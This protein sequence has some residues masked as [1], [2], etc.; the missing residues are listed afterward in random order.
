[1]ASATLRTSSTNR[2]YSGLAWP[3]GWLHHEVM[4]RQEQDRQDARDTLTRVYLDQAGIRAALAR[5]R[6]DTGAT[7]SGAA[8]PGL[9]SRDATR[10]EI[11]EWRRATLEAADSAHHAILERLTASFDSAQQPR[12][13]PRERQRILITLDRINQANEGTWYAITSEI[14]RMADSA[15]AANAAD[16]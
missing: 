7:R 14:N 9:S 5:A 3:V 10:V 1:M 8:A 2:L 13:S 6:D 16:P 15:T 11:N 12:I 4:A